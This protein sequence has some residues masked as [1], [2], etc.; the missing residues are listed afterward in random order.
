MASSQLFVPV[1]PTALPIS[2]TI[3]I[4]HPS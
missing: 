4:V 2:V 1:P 3:S